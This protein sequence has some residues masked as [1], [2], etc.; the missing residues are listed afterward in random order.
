MDVMV[1]DVDPIADTN[2][3]HVCMEAWS[4]YQPDTSQ[5]LVAIML[6]CCCDGVAAHMSVALYSRCSLTHWFPS[7]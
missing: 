6:S 1:L 7:L 5:T 3:V 2:I 4:R